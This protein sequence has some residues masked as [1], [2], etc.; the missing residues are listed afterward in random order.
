MSSESDTAAASTG[1]VVAG[2]ALAAG[3]L[4]WPVEPVAPGWPAVSSP[5]TVALAALAVGAF[6]F[7]RHGLL[8]RR[9]GTLVAGVATIALVG[10]AFVVLIAPFGGERPS[11]AA[12][13]LV[14]LFGGALAATAA[15]A[16]RR[17]VE[18]ETLLSW[19]REVGAGGLIGLTGLAAG[20]LL[21][22][23]VVSP[24]AAATDASM[25]TLFALGTL[26]FG[27]GL[28]LV[29]V[30]FLVA[31]DR[32]LSYVDVAAPGLRDVAYAI[33]GVL[34]LVAVAVAINAVFTLFDVPTAQNSVERT[35]RSEGAAVLLWSIPLAWLAIGLGEELVFRGIVQR[36]LA[37]TFTTG[38]AILLA[39]VI[40]ALV[41]VPAYFD[42]NP[43]AMTSVLG[44]VFALSLILG[45]AYA[46]TRNLLVPIFI[47]GTYNAVVFLSL[48]VS[49]TGGI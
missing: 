18:R 4:P 42:P 25:P 34:V 46:K 47:H 2:L 22:A 13:P 44:V 17:G 16:D 11:F 33:G 28:V 20:T 38:R 15:Y 24:V 26:F 6:L 45:Y 40:F 48:Y 29:A 23:V 27:I 1:L 12:G 49:L 35:A 41:H 5:V 9:P 14:A 31:T 10:Y 19:S 43:L 32:G 39:S 8:D 3:L 7:R 37:E 36:H 30:G 21:P